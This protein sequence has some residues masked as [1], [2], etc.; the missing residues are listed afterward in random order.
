MCM[1]VCATGTSKG[2]ELRPLATC[3][4]HTTA[5]GSRAWVWAWANQD[6]EALDCKRWNASHVRV[7][8]L[9]SCDV[10]ELQQAAHKAALL[11]TGDLSLNHARKEALGHPNFRC[12]RDG[13]TPWR[14]S[15]TQ[16]KGLFLR[17]VEVDSR[18]TTA[19]RAPSP[20][21]VH[22]LLS[23]TPS[24]DIRVQAQQT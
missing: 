11:V 16:A 17:Y 22:M 24:N 6:N 2:V 14:K 1:C 5:R 20:F 13:L 18:K 8:A 12:Q 7:P 23:A 15:R 21:H 3:I 4:I 9:S 10:V 19:L